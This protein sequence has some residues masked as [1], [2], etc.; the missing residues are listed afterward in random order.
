MSEEDGPSADTE[1]LA[2]RA[3][4]DRMWEPNSR[5]NSAWHHML[6][7]ED[8]AMR[9]GRRF[10]RLLPGTRRCKNCSAP[11]DGFGGQVMRLLGRRQYDRNPLFCSF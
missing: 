1:P 4:Y 7:G 8:P 9:R 5:V 11:F 10:R 2:E 3:S 6:T